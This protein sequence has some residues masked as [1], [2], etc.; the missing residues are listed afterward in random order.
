MNKQDIDNQI[1]SYE[2]QYKGYSEAVNRLNEK[3][4]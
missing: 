1:Q 4:K 2:V 3:I